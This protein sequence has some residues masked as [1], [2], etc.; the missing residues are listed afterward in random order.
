MLRGT[1]S[2]KAVKD[3]DWG[4][5]NLYEILGLTSK[6]T[7]EEIRQAYRQLAKRFHP[8]AGGNADQFSKLQ[9]AYEVLSNPVPRKAYD[10]SGVVQDDQYWNNVRKVAEEKLQELLN[11][12]LDHMDNPGTTD[13][14]S[15]LMDQVRK[16]PA[17]M[18]R[19]EQLTKNEIKKIK[20]IRSRF[21][22]KRGRKPSPLVIKFFDDKIIPLEKRLKNI[23]MM[24]DVNQAV[25]ALIEDW[26]YKMDK[27]PKP[28]DYPNRYEWEAA[29][30]KAGFTLPSSSRD[31]TFTIRRY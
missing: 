21:K 8:D 29:M 7:V 26:D 4:S 19:N 14:M 24:R 1:L 20:A 10:K 30:R 15:L 23:Q 12:L 18:D 17:E 25:K 31:F 9:K 2:T 16:G 5:D 22:A 3:P 6:A 27:P 11:G 28:E 13:V